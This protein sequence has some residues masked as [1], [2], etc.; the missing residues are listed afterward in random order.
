MR[1]PARRDFPRTHSLDAR[2]AKNAA[3]LSDW[4]RQT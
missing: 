3:R 2:V 1:V 4:E